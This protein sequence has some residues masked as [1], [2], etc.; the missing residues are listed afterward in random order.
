M[1]A[2]AI[3]A[4]VVAAWAAQ[5][6][7]RTL[8]AR[9]EAAARQPMRAV[10]VAA[11]D[12]SAD[13]QLDAHRVAV[14]DMPTEWLP[15]DA[16]LPEQFDAAQ[17]ATLRRPVRRGDPILAGYLEHRAAHQPFSAQLA[18]GRRAVTI[19]VDE[20]SSLSGMLE[21]GDLIDLY[22]SFQHEHRRVTAPLLQGVRVLATGHQRG[23]HDAADGYGRGYATVTLD[24]SPEDAVRLVAARQQG[25]IS[26]MLRHAGDAQPASAPVSGDLATLLGI[27]PQAVARPRDVPVIFGD[28]G[29][30][31][32]PGLN[33]ADA[34]ARL[35][36]AG[37][38]MR[39]RADEAF[40]GDLVR[41]EPRDDRGIVQ[42]P[43]QGIAAGM[44]P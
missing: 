5:H 13:T 35:E 31:A 32:I 41:A 2:L 15:A 33:D 28:R 36:E 21:P 24:A 34:A 37:S 18:A 29:P 44:A 19:P 20:I 7:L 1:L 16:L 40:A 6:H 9:L 22:V 25:S 39:G 27:A 23:E 4:G 14:R 11:V 8:A 12:L 17:G 42:S 43:G 38:G 26:A 30:R 10:V 3:V